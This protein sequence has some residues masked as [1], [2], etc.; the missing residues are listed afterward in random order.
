MAV[1]PRW[2]FVAVL[3]VAVALVGGA[4]G[5]SAKK[6]VAGTKL[7][8]LGKKLPKAIQDSGVVRVGSDIEYAPIES[9]KENTK[10][11]QGLDIDVADAMGAKL[12]VKLRFID[13]TDFAG[14]ILA[15]RSGR[16]DIIMSAMNDTAER[17]GK[18]V[19]FIDYFRAGT[20]I[21]AKKG[22]PESVKSLDDLC[23][24][25]VSVQKGTVQ[26]TDIIAPQQPKCTAAGKPRID[27]LGFE[28]DTDAL[29]QVKVGRAVADLEDF[30]VAAYNAKT[31]GGGEDFE[32]VG[33]PGFSV[34]QYGIAVP[35]EQ[36]ALRDALRAA[37]RA[38]ISDG[39]YDRLLGKWNLTGGALKTAPLNGGG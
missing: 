11:A 21:V 13:D 2:R 33:Q 3:V 31:S 14:I 17:R 23:G 25:T 35:K 15:L 12:G 9:F 1:I 19:D 28:K 29:Q 24:K 22:N 10:I 4:C 34:G 18:G 20:S 26:E 32:V 36:R 8:S 27:V 7:T 5:K 39:T 16:F 38:A 30:P 6:T 37:L